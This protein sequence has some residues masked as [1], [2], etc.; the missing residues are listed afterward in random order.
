LLKALFKGAA[1]QRI[2]SI[3][4]QLAS[5][6]A[7]RRLAFEQLHM[8]M[9]SIPKNSITIKK[10]LADGLN[11]RGWEAHLEVSVTSYCIII[12]SLI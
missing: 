5:N 10:A 3:V 7:A 1:L 11:R 8:T 2:A 12:I 4:S 9:T 6:M